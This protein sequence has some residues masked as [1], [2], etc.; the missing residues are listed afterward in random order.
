MRIAEST[1]DDLLLSN[2]ALGIAGE[3]DRDIETVDLS[4]SVICEVDIA[5]EIQSGR[6]ASASIVGSFNCSKRD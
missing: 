5:G 4:S 1:T 6:I 2:F 3:A